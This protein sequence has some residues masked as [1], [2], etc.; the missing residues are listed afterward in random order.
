MENNIKIMYELNLHLERNDIMKKILCILL[1]L[2][3]VLSIAACGGTTSGGGDDDD[4]SP[5][6]SKPDKTENTDKP[7]GTGEG[8]EVTGEYYD[9][10]NFKAIVPAGWKAF[11]QHD[12]FSD[13]PNEMNP[14]RL[15]ICKG[16]NDDWD[17]FTKPNVQIS[18]GGAS[19]TLWATDE[20]WYEDVEALEPYVSGNHTWTG[21]KGTSLGYKYIFL[22]EDTGKIQYQ[23]SI[24]Y[25]TDAGS[26][27]LDD[28]DVKAILASIEPTNADDLAAMAEAQPEEPA[29][30]E[31]PGTTEDPTEPVDVPATPAADYGWWEGEWYGW[32]CV[33]DGTGVFENLND[34]AWDAYAEINVY[35][36]GTGIITLWDTETS[37]NSPLMTCWLTFEPGTDERGAMVADTGSF[38]DSG[39]WLPNW[40]VNAEPIAARDWI[41]DSG[42]STVSHF[43]DMIE[44][45]GK[46]VDPYYSTESFTYHIYLRPWGTL[47]EDVKTGDTSGCIYRD[48][49]PLYYDGWY[50]PLLEKGVDSLPASFSAGKELLG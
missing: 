11:P 21:F 14:N 7:E 30:T 43:D 44:I 48:M 35:Y 26:I 46:Y 49:M 2:L 13:D 20:S 25:E 16:G 39:S 47:W 27:S 3:L 45:V 40:S 50:L 12:V 17:L 42:N 33:K 28:A 5:K 36:D 24:M 31:E 6:T 18:Y 29:A 1:S 4:D 8:G 34:L 37:R 32:W 41:S 22:Y 38:F 9:T 23:I 19:T 15:T 10:G